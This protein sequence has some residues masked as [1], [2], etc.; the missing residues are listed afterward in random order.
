MSPDSSEV[1]WI[2]YA[3][4]VGYVEEIDSA[5]CVWEIYETDFINVP[6]DYIVPDAPDRP[7]KGL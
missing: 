2:L 6:S 3:A 7:G 5:V 1:G 4:F